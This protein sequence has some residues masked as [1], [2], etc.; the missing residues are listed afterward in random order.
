MQAKAANIGAALVAA[1][2]LAACAQAPAPR[3]VPIT[4]KAPAHENN[5]APAPKSRPLQ[6][7]ERRP[8]SA[9]DLIGKNTDLAR[10]K[11]GKPNLVSREGGAALMLYRY[12]RCA[13]HVL[14]VTTSRGERVR[15]IH[16]RD[17]KTGKLYAADSKIST[18]CLKAIADNNAPG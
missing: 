15:S 9:Q 6:K 4:L 17:I 13:A 14:S 3:S 16:V 10:A 5:A 1:G 11:L 8:L 12:D 18:G 2:L 7:T